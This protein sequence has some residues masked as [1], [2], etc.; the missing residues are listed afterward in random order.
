MPSPP[1]QPRRIAVVGSTC[2]GK[3]TLA[4]QLAA[5]IGGQRIEL[6]ALHWLPD[7]Q[8][9]PTDEFR[10]SVRQQ[11]AA[12]CW[13]S[14]GNYS[15]ARDLVWGRATDVVWL[16]HSFPTVAARAL[17]R[18]TRRVITREPLYA[19]NRETFAKS[20]L[21]T[22]SILVWLARTFRQNRRQ[23]AAL[24]DSDEWPAVTFTRLHKQAEVHAFVS[25]LKSIV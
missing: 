16:D 6:D 9:Q 8:E 22:D 21:S 18:T 15:K 2:S 23:Y 13:V 7:W 10:E 4:R 12:D 25:E 3:S 14:D 11:V 1:T 19:D 5:V 20:F 24:M 17:C